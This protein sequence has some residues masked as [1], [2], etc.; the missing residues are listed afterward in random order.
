MQNLPE[1]ERRLFEPRHK[2]GGVIVKEQH[3]HRARNGGEE[4][5]PQ[6][7]ELLRSAYAIT[8]PRFLTLRR[9]D[10]G[11]GAERTRSTRRSKRSARSNARGRRAARRD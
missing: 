9:F 3:L 6:L 8:I 5:R 11:R 1:A 2:S 4:R 7:A 10:Q